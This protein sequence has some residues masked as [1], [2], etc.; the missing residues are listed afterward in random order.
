MAKY[1]HI[2]KDKRFI[3]ARRIVIQRDKGLCQ[4]CLKEGIYRKGTEVHHI[5]MLNEKNQHNEVIA[6]GTDNLILLCKNCHNDAHERNSGI[7]KFVIPV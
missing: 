4:H 7:T 5:V 1:T 2:Y 6:F 3:K